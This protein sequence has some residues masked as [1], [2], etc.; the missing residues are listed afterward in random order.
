MTQVG[1]GCFGR[2]SG[3]VCN[4]P[5]FDDGIREYREEAARIYKIKKTEEA[6]AKAEEARRAARKSF[7]NNLPKKG[8]NKS[9]KNSS[10][11]K[12]KLTQKKK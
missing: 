11:K 9:K 1:K 10:V 6:K 3:K 12:I 4:S 7:L 2:S 5:T 8:G